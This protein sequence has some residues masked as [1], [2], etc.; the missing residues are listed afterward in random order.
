MASNRIKNINREVFSRIWANYLNDS[1]TWI[2]RKLKHIHFLPFFKNRTRLASQFIEFQPNIVVEH[3]GHGIVGARCFT[4]PNHHDALARHHVQVLP[5]FTQ[6]GNHIVGCSGEQRA[7]EV[8]LQT[9]QLVARLPVQPPE[10][11][12]GFIQGLRRCHHLLKKSGVGEYGRGVPSAA[13]LNEDAVSGH[14]PRLTEQDVV[15][16][17][18]Y[19]KP[20]NA[21]FL[22]EFL[23]EKQVEILPSCCFDDPVQESIWSIVVS[24]A[25]TSIGEVLQAGVERAGIFWHTIIKAGGHCELVF[26][27]DERLF[28]GRAGRPASAEV[29]AGFVLDVEQA[30]LL[31]NTDKAGRHAFPRRCPIPGTILGEGAEVFFEDNFAIFQDYECLGIV[32][33]EQVIKFLDFVIAPAERIRG[34]GFPGIARE[35]REVKGLGADFTEGKKQCKDE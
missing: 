26:D 15:V 14:A 23:I 19:P 35:G 13:V 29:V 22:R 4:H 28:V 34:E 11:A 30:F 33:F 9:R 32:G 24:P 18:L 16:I 25:G 10:V 31:R 17:N 6:S 3:D 27:G 1:I 7:G 20:G 5:V 8:D 12:V 21:C 2:W